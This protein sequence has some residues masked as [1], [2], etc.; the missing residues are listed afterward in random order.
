[1]VRHETDGPIDDTL[2]RTVVQKKAKTTDS[3]PQLLETLQ[4]ADSALA[5]SHTSTPTVKGEGKEVD[6][7]S[8]LEIKTRAAGKSLDMDETAAQLWISQTPRL[9][10]GYYKNDLSNDVQVRNMTQNVRDWE[11]SNQKVLCS[12]D[13]LLNRIIEIVKGN[14]SRAAVVKYD[15]GMKLEIIAVEE[16]KAPPEGVD[17]KWQSGKQGTEDNKLMANKGDQYKASKR[18]GNEHI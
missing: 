14:D 8:V 12:L 18:F 17:A 13:Y 5:L 11:R 9:A 3:L 4:L 6:C 7:S 10:A 2:G 1:M 15:G 16:Q